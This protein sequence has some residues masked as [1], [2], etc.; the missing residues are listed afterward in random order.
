M[1]EIRYLKRF[2]LRNPSRWQL[3]LLDYTV[4]LNPDDIF[5]PFFKLKGDL[6]LKNDLYLNYINSTA[7]IKP[8]HLK[9]FPNFSLIFSYLLLFFFSASFFRSANR[10]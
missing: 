3:T 5:E 8:K 4:C 6:R 10:Y 1:M 7:Y 2:R 9:R